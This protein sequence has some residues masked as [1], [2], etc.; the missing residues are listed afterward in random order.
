M[1]DFFVR[2]SVPCF[3]GV[4]TAKEKAAGHVST[5]TSCRPATR[6]HPSISPT[7][8]KTSRRANSSRAQS[9]CPIA[10]SHTPPS[11]L[12]DSLSSTLL[13]SP[14]DVQSTDSPHTLNIYDP[15][16]HPISDTHPDGLS[17]PDEDGESNAG[18]SKSD[19]SDDEY[20]PDSEALESSDDSEDMTPQSLDY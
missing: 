3:Y 4:V 2:S 7:P 14:N 19:K 12:G 5:S 15:S 17:P 13:A 10:T 9:R 18:E 20:A 16:L 8:P 11:N 1:I 6:T